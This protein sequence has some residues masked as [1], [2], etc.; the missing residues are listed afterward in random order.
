M[1]EQVIEFAVLHPGQ[2]CPDLGRRVNQGRPGRIP[3]V[4]EGDCA[5]GQLGYLDATSA[6][7]ACPTLAPARY[8]QLVSRDAVR[9]LHRSL[10]SSRMKG[11]ARDGRHWRPPSGLQRN[12]LTAFAEAYCKINCRR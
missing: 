8:R 1:P 11:R 2:E 10:L 12:T 9:D 6:R 4:A 5:A 3:G 7:V